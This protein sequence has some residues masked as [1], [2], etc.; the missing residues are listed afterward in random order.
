MTATSTVQI[1]L[2]Y[3]IGMWLP[4]VKQNGTN[5]IS[6][7]NEKVLFVRSNTEKS[8]RLRTFSP[9]FLEESS[10]SESSPARV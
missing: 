6:R 9:E 10:S 7:M 4:D 8:I 3:V 1:P 5:F 2:R